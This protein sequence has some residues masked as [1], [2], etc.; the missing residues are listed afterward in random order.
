MKARKRKK[1]R[2]GIEWKA[3]QRKKQRNK[4]GISQEDTGWQGDMEKAMGKERERT[5][6]SREKYEKK[7]RNA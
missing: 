4:E 2:S 1:G 3:R 5:K 6:K 7:E